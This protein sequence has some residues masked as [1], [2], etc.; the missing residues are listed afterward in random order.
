MTTSLHEFLFTEKIP[1]LKIWYYLDDKDGCK[2]TIGEKNNITIEEIKIK[3][4]QNKYFKPTYK[5]SKKNDQGDWINIPFSSEKE[6]ES[7]Q[8][9]YTIFLKYTENLYCIDIDDS[10][11]KN[12]DDFISQTGCDTFKDCCWVAGNTKGIH[13]YAKIKNMIEYTNQVD[14]YKK[15]KG[16]LIHAKNNMWEKIDKEVHNYDDKIIE[17][18]YDD[19]KDLFND[20]LNPKAQ[21][22]A[23]KQKVTDHRISEYYVAGESLPPNEQNVVEYQREESIDP[24]N[25][26]EEYKK[27]EFFFKNGFDSERYD[28]IEMSQIGYA[29]QSMFG[30][31]YGKPMFLSFAKKYSKNTDWEQEYTD[32]F[33][34]YMKPSHDWNMGFFTNIFKKH[35]MELYEKLKREYNQKEKQEEIALKEQE[36]MNNGNIHVTDDNDAAEYIL[37]QLNGQIVYCRGQIF[38]KNNNIWINSKIVIDSFILDFILTAKMYKCDGKKESPFGQNVKNAK[39]IREAL[40]CKITKHT[41][42]SFYDKFHMTTKGRLAFLDGVLDFWAKVFYKWE[43]VDFEYYT[44][45]QINRNFGDYFE[46]PNREIIELVKK[47]IYDVAFGD[48]VDTALHFLSRGIAGHNEDKN[49]ATYIGNRDCGKGV[50]YDS[51]V[52]AFE[53]YVKSFELSMIQYQRKSSS[54]E[55]SRKMYWLLDLEFVRLGINQEI[56]SH[57]QCMQTCGKTLKKM[58][59]GNDD[60]IARRNYDR[61]DTHFKIDTTFFMM[62]NNGLL[63][64]TDDAFEHRIE[65]TSVIQFKTQEEIDQMKSNGVDPRVLEIYKIKD[66]N[67]KMKCTTNDWRNAMVFLLFENYK[68]SPVSTA[69]KSDDIEDENTTLR[70][71]I[72]EKFDFTQDSNDQILCSTVN[73]ILGHD[74]KKVTSELQ[75]MHIRKIKSK[76]KMYRDKAVYIGIKEKPNEDEKDESIFDGFGQLKSAN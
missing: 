19:I 66:E 11:I 44:T 18:E 57:L 33:E 38:F 26:S 68:T 28:H 27:L 45:Q 41:D 16:D 25:L 35:N 51:L 47:K 46:N 9:V 55:T 75:S 34:K 58:T 21:P 62:G 10:N 74:K 31:K 39:N 22:Q 30:V 69:K 12:M 67:I 42:D 37:T 20:R 53:G 6:R 60:M 61:V 8:Q 59:G 1:Y 14:V 4:K 13:I 71:L 36:L 43:E 15:F 56:P 50:I 76:H 29:I 23:K 52:N 3:N 5:K 64:D 49:W 24:K 7:L 63:V 40:Y 48:K 65:F 72:L 73:D 17:L 2:Q 54:D 32:K 70:Q